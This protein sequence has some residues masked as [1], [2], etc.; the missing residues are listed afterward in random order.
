MASWPTPGAH[1]RRPR[2]Y[3]P[4]QSPP[5]PDPTCPSDQEVT[6][7]TSSIIRS[8]PEGP[9]RQG[10]PP[11]SWPQPASTVVDDHQHKHPGCPRLRVGALHGRREDASASARLW[12]DAQP[13]ARVKLICRTRSRGRGDGVQQAQALA[14]PAERTVMRAPRHGQICQNFCAHLSANSTVTT[15]GTSNPLRSA[16]APWRTSSVRTTRRSSKSLATSTKALL[17]S[18]ECTGQRVEKEEDKKAESRASTCSSGSE[19]A[20]SPSVCSRPRR[21]WLKARRAGRFKLPTRCS[22]SRQKAERSAAS[23]AVEE[24]SARRCARPG[25]HE[26]VC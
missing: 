14:P 19:C 20:L 13:Y 11:A 2:T 22:S 12:Y 16:A 6:W 3:R 9:G 5:A 18:G 10:D 4:N 17:S 21:P 23:N 8:N 26:R 1:A 25:E 7:L 24:A 15:R